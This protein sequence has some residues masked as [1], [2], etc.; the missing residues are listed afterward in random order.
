MVFRSRT[1]GSPAA[2]LPAAFLS[3]PARASINVREP[4]VVSSGGASS[5]RNSFPTLSLVF[6]SVITKSSGIVS[7]RLSKRGEYHR[8]LIRK[9]SGSAF[10]EKYFHTVRRGT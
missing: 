10:N 5:P 8:A 6:P 2:V 1:C 9:R 3:A 4:V 7:D